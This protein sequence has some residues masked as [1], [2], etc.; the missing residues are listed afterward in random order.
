VASIMF[1]GLYINGQWGPGNGR[2]TVD[3]PGTGEVLAEVATASVADCVAAVDAAHAAAPAWASKAPRER[4]E[5]LRRAFELMHAEQDPIAELIVRENGKVLS[6]ARGEVG[7]AAEFFRWFSE[8]AVRIEGEYRLAPNGDKRILV[9]AAPVGVAVLVTPWNFPA[10]MATRKIAPALAAGCTAV[11]KP[12]PETPLTALYLAELLGRAGVPAGVLNVVLP[13][14]PAEAVAAMLGHPAVR[15]LSFTGSTVVGS[16]LLALA[17]PHVLSTSMELGGNAPFIVLAGAD[18]DVAVPAALVAK[19]RNTGAS[20]IAANRFYVHESLAASFTAALAQAMGALRV[21]DGLA[22]GAEVGA[23][24]SAG[25]QHKVVELVE[26]ATKEGAKVLVGGEVPRRAGFFYPPTVLSD[27]G[28]DA[29]ILGTEI[30]G[31]VAPVTTFV[32]PDE[33]I[34]AANAT[35]FGLMA[36]V[37]GELGHCLGVA[38]RLDVGMVGINRGVISD[39]A[40]PFGGVKQS[41]IGREGGHQGIEE[42]L[43]TKY[44]GLDW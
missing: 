23:L 21:D 22:P 31:P 33:A 42:F 9:T 25:E 6:E 34:A 2:M 30:F 14:P 40:A 8:E 39:P 3:E 38:E 5:V 11:L 20:C 26:H 7:Y 36:Y 10:A 15:K 43:E 32:D 41:G 12:A 16:E 13:E 37:C 1:T 44:I 4:A 17:A 19:M 27:V 28:R 35:P 18:L 29:S 24:V